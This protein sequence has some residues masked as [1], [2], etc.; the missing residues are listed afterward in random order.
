MKRSEIKERISERNF[1]IPTHERSR[2]GVSSKDRGTG[3]AGCVSRCTEYQAAPS[4]TWLHFIKQQIWPEL[5]SFECKC[6]KT[7]TLHLVCAHKQLPSANTRRHK[8]INNLF[9]PINYDTW[10]YTKTYQNHVTYEPINHPRWKLRTWDWKKGYPWPKEQTRPPVTW[11]SPQLCPE[12]AE[13][14][15]LDLFLATAQVQFL[16]PVTLSPLQTDP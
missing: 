16:L 7:M 5:L 4:L 15:S 13:G 8:L 11:A 2:H 9:V 12:S 1:S 3:R 14:K 6:Q 10:K